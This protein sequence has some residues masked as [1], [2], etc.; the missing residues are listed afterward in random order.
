MPGGEPPR[1]LGPRGQ[2]PQESPGRQRGPGR[3]VRG[4]AR[5]RALARSTRTQGS[6][7]PSLQNH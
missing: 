1:D 6:P 7:V 2:Q 5:M 4:G 3:A